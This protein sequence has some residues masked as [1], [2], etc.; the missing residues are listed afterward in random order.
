MSGL[1]AFLDPLFRLPLFAG[2][3]VAAVL[4]LLGTLLRLRDEWLAALGLAHLAAAGGLLAVAAGT[5]LVAGALAGGVLGA[6]GKGLLGAR[7]NTAY[8]L[9]VLA[10]W[11]AALLVA[12]STPL[13]AAH[14]HALA[15]GQLYFARW[16][17]VVAGALALAATLAAWRRLSARLVRT[18]LLPLHDRANGLPAWRWQ[19]GFDLL[20]ALA[21]AAGTAT[22]GLMAAFALAFVPPWAAFRV[23]PG[24]REAARVSV[25]LGVGSYL[26]AF[27]WAAALDLPFGPVLVVALLLGAGAVR[28]YG[29]SIPSLSTGA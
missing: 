29:A 6:I 1:D 9:M 23:A 5:P 27:A 11:S 8:G 10:G 25:A 12:A 14:G 7:G 21:L 4:P 28:A 22:V 15:E 16:P 20:V 2:L 26:A 17:Q 18:R 13:G 24:W 3:L 19:L